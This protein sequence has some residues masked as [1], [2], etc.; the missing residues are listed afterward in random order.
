MQTIIRILALSGLLVAPAT[1]FGQ[2]AESGTPADTNPMEKA[3]F[4][5]NDQTA[6]QQSADQLACY[7]WASEQDK[8]DPEADE[9]AI[10][11]AHEQALAEAGRKRRKKRQANSAYESAVKEHETELAEWGKQWT[12]CMKGK[13]YTVE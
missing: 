10:H 3:V 11:A 1:V 8:W 7:Q 6:E 12:A 2:E 5:A 9:A 13:G 4:P